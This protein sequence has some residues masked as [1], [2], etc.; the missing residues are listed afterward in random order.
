M[1]YFGYPEEPGM[2]DGFWLMGL[3]P[4]FCIVAQLLVGCEINVHH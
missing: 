1:S 3:V 4:V 2:G